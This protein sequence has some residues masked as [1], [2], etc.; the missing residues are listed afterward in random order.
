MG[1]DLEENIYNVKNNYISLKG[2]GIY[3]LVMLV[4]NN[5]ANLL[6]IPNDFKNTNIAPTTCVITG[7]ILVMMLYML[8][9]LVTAVVMKFIVN[10]LSPDN[11]FSTGVSWVWLM[12]SVLPQTAYTLFTY[13]ILGN[14]EYMTIAS[15]GFSVLSA[16]IYTLI[17]KIYNVFDKQSKY[18]YTCLALLIIQVGFLLLLIK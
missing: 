18:A 5:N 16:L 15:I 14:Q 11:K 13:N 3:T 8:I 2:I 10:M 1:L 4:L 7:R 6:I 12:M 9:P 17:M